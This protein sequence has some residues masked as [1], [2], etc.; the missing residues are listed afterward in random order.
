MILALIAVFL[1]LP[2]VQS[3]LSGDD[4]VGKQ[5]QEGGPTITISNRWNSVTALTDATTTTYRELSAVVE[6]GTNVIFF[7]GLGSSNGQA[8]GDT[9]DLV[10][11]AASDTR[12]WRNLTSSL[13]SSPSSRFGAAS[14]SFG[15]FLVL[16]GGRSGLLFYYY[17]DYYYYCFLN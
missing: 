15:N 4:V 16:F 6:I 1:L 3:T 12:F 10:Y 7:G 14:T 8:L 9:V 11:D 13:V 2:L 5:Q 17:S